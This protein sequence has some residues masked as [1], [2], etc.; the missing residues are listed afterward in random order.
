MTFD[1]GLVLGILI[2]SGVLF[3]TE[4][5]RMDV[6]ALLVLATLAVTGLVQPNEALSGFSS[7]AVITVWAMFMLSAGLT[8]TGVTNV[9]GRQVLKLAGTGETRIVFVVMITSGVLSAFMANIG[10]AALMLPV[11]MDVARRTGRPPSRLL[12]P[13]AFASLL[14]GLT[15]LIGSSPNLLVSDALREAGH[16][17]LELF[18]FLPVG[19]AVLLAVTVF[20]AVVARR[21]LPERDPGRRWS[22]ARWSRAGSVSP[23]GSTCSSSYA[24]IR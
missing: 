12:M 23:P 14:G 7:P 21:W 17:P 18:D 1:I 3:V 16:K 24:T 11:V 9:I 8:Q 5:I 6:T 19:G 2:V 20:F 10:V 13:L 22:V 15:T 4:W